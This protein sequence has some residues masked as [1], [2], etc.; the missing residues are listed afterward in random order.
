MNTMTAIRTRRSPNE[1]LDGALRREDLQTIAEAGNYAP[2]FGRLH[3]TVIDS[4]ALIDTISA[5]SQEMM[6]HS[7]NEFA[8]KMANTPGYSAVRNAQAFVVISAPGGNNEMGFAMANA[9]C[10]AENMCLAATELGIGSRF[11]MGPVMSLAQEPIKS[12][13]NLSEGYQALVMVALGN[14]ADEMKE[15]TRSQDNIDYASA[16]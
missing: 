2:I 6:K 3:F 11:M 14:V 4:R 9:S 10:A 16:E 7:G 5:V 1:F 13:V 15:R 12:G 8:E